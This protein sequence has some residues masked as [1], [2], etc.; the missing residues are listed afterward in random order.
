MTFS[1]THL[2]ESLAAYLAPTFP[3]VT[4]YTDPNQ[5]DTQCP[6]MFLQ[7]RYAYTER[8]RN[9]HGYYLRRIGVDLTYL[10][11]YNLPNL[12]QLYDAAEE[13]LDP[14][15]QSF[16]YSDG[17]G[18]TELLRTSERNSRTDLDGLH[19]MFELQVWAVIPETVLKMQTMDYDE[20]VVLP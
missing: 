6:C 5:Q 18:E 20:E 11:D 2:A 1:I 4:F 12:Q 8:R 7:K 3:G 13:A 15:M 16:P 19:Y 14:V 17:S 9:V 10:E